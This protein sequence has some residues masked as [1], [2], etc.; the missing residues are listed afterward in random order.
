MLFN[1]SFQSSR[2]CLMCRQYK[3]CTPWVEQHM[4]TNII[5]PL[6]WALTPDLCHSS[7]GMEL[8]CGG[9]RMCSIAVFHVSVPHFVMYFRM[10]CRCYSLWNVWTKKSIWRPYCEQGNI[11]KLWSSWASKVW[12]LL[13][14]SWLIQDIT[15]WLI[16]LYLFII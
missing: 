11:Q 2:F 10:G 1:I 8:H 14:N 16:F 6:N 3:F 7:L 13:L 5:L 12:K 4:F 15:F 9:V